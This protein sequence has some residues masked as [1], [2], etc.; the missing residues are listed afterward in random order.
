ME[1]QAD[2]APLM[3]PRDAAKLLNLPTQTIRDMINRKELLAFRVGNQWRISRSEVAKLVMPAGLAPEKI[4]F[5][6]P[7]KFDQT[8][9]I[10]LKFN[11]ISKPAQNAYTNDL[12]E[13]TKAANQ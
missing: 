6:D 7:A 11:V 1:E 4:G 10:A 13:A 8:A 12:M 2:L 9:A 5:I 3:S